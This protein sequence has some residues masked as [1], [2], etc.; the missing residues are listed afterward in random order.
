MS[1]SGLGVL[2]SILIALFFCILIMWLE[3]IE[4]YMPRDI[5]VIINNLKNKER[6]EPEVVAEEAAEPEVVTEEP[7]KPGVVVK[8]VKPLKPVKLSEMKD[9]VQ[10]AKHANELWEKQQNELQMRRDQKIREDR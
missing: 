1:G 8:P 10:Q 5:K 2:V 4:N 7:P 9:P 6:G 3:P